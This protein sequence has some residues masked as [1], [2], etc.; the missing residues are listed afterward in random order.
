MVTTVIVGGS[1]DDYGKPHP[2]HTQVT[3]CQYGSC[4]HREQIGPHMFYWMAIDG[5]HTH[6][7]FPLMVDLVHMFVEDRMMEEPA[8]TEGSRAKLISN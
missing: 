1:Y 7:G 4:H 5:G 2:C 6:W 3:S 8:D